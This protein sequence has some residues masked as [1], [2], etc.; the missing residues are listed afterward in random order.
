MA[1]HRGIGRYAAIHKPG[2]AMRGTLNCGPGGKAGT[3]GCRPFPFHD[4]LLEKELQITALR[5]TQEREGER[6]QE[7]PPQG[8]PRSGGHMPPAATVAA[9]GGS[10]D[11]AASMRTVG[12][13]QRAGFGRKRKGPRKRASSSPLFLFK[14]LPVVLSRSALVFASRSQ[15]SPQHP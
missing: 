4:P 15:A 13:R 14:P 1:N 6:G 9:A 2:V 11:S 3:T 5:Y 7:R 10:R 8:E 12:S